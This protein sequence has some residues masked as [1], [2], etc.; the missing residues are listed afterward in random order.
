TNRIISV[1]IGEE[2]VALMVIDEEGDFKA[3]L[4]VEEAPLCFVEQSRIAFGLE[5]LMFGL[6]SSLM[7]SLVVCI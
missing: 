6:L 5:E 4:F 7:L 3:S 1:A 2:D